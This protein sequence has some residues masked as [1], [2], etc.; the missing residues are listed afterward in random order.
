MRVVKI[1]GSSII[2]SLIFLILIASFAYAADSKLTFTDVDV[3][4]GSKT[5]KNLDDGDSIGD[6]ASPG[7]SV[8]FKIKVE[9]NFTSEEDLDIEDITITVTIEE[10][11]DGDDI[12]EESSTFDLKPGRDKSTTLK[13]EVPFEVDEDSYNVLIVAEGEDE[14]GTDH[15]TEMSLS[16]D[17]DKESHLLKLTRKTLNPA[18]VTC[19]RKNIQFGVTLLNIG[20]EDEDDVSLQLIN[21]DLNLNIKEELD[22]IVSDFDDEANTF[23]K[24]YSFNVPDSVEAGSYPITLRVLYNSDRKKLEETATLDVNE[25]IINQVEEPEIIEEEEETEEEDVIVINPPFEDEETIVIPEGTVVTQESFFS[26]NA[27][28]IGIIIIEV[29]IVI[30]GI[31]LLIMFLRNK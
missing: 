10:I 16:L 23:S 21:D 12:E 25:C 22:E 31:V 7:D 8:E 15:T 29:I 5:S 17:V 13:F 24:V 27:F 4:V 1:K 3:K 2:F 28:V 30:V 20:N 26:G 6:D 19:A 14:N 11:D 9:N 18:Q